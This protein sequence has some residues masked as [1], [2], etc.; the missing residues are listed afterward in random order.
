MDEEDL[1]DAEEAK[2]LATSDSFAGLGLTENEMMGRDG[3]MDILR[4]AGDT[5]GVQLLKRM[6][7]REGQ[8]VGPKVRRKTRLDDNHDTEESDEIH[9]FAPANSEMISFVRKNDFKGLG[10]EGEGRL[11]EVSANSTH[12]DQNEISIDKQSFSLTEPRSK[13]L[14]QKRGGIGI[15]ILNDTG[16]DDEDAYSIGPSIKYNR[17]IGGDK[18]KKKKLENGKPSHGSS[19]PLLRSKPVFI[20]KKTATS[21]SASA[22]RRCHDGR[23]P[24]DGFVM[25]TDSDSLS[26]LTDRKKYPPPA[27][28][29]D[30]KSSKTTDP[31]PDASTPST[32]KSA[33]DI[34]RAS[35]LNPSA[36]AALL[37]EA[38]LPGKSVFD[39]LTPSARS[40]IATATQNPNLPPALDESPP[41]GYISKPS[42]LTSLIPPLDPTIAAAALSRGTA[43]WMPYAE[44]LPKRARYR[45]F[46]SISANLRS[47][48]PDR[49][50]GTNTDEW[51][52]E[53]R[54]FAH[55][56]QVFKP[57]TGMMASRFTTSRATAAN[58]NGF[59]PTGSS[60]DEKT[61]LS[62]PA[63]QPTDPAEEAA[64]LGMFG[65]LTRSIV[66]FYPSRLLCKRFNVPPPEHV[67]V[68]A[69]A[70]AAAANR[71]AD[72]H[73]P[74]RDQTASG[75]SRYPPSKNLDLVGQKEMDALRRES[76]FGRE[77]GGE[78]GVGKGEGEGGVERVA[79]VVVDPLVNEA[80]EGRRAGEAVFRAV[81]GSDSDG[82]GD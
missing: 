37:G 79:A 81:F 52:H 18:P 1:A 9:W 71:A 10:Y 76:G 55:A 48:L 31:S 24:L 16:S 46:L 12:K 14:A 7:W 51:V 19:N 27:I 64:G 2:K 36:R 49:L 40:R 34:A 29:P 13:K 57:M 63:P 6:G 32:Y 47:G 4:V 8:G 22:L 80:L 20:S 65:P 28:P 26:S 21:K 25:S 50:P 75:V 3:L 15:G 5:K 35:T 59:Q 38:S 17:V 70:A 41:E 77:I 72:E 11:A 44:D 78:G 54:E 39:Y 73:D 30:W 61:L 82:D 69:S 43:G 53:M 67:Q 56:A 42:D 33:A 68:D 62:H 23:L 74:V 60:T 45:T 66:P 58:S